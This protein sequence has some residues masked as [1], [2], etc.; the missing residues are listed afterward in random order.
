LGL[1]APNVLIVE[2]RPMSSG[3]GIFLHLRELEGKPVTLSREDVTSES[4]VRGADE[5]NV[6]EEVL[7]EGVASVTLKPYEVKFVRLMFR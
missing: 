1:N 7:Q 3:A 5:V 6:L 4:E 2:A